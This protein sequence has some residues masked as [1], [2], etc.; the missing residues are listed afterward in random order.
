M[1]LDWTHIWMWYVLSGPS[2]FLARLDWNTYIDMVYFF[3]LFRHFWNFVKIL[4]SGQAWWGMDDKCGGSMCLCISWSLYLPETEFRF[5]ILYVDLE[6]VFTCQVLSLYWWY[7]CGSCFHLSES[8][9]TLLV[10]VWILWV[11]LA[12]CVVDANLWPGDGM[13]DRLRNAYCEFSALCKQHKIRTSPSI[14][15]GTACF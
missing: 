9:F 15:V 10:Y 7:M 1:D 11:L 13:D 14:H 12:C 8:E 5:N 3:W 6:L 2:A 4:E